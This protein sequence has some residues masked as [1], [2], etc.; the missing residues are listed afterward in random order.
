MMI[1][2]TSLIRQFTLSLCGVFLFVIIVEW[3]LININTSEQPSLSSLS[4]LS[5]ET[6]QLLSE[7]SVLQ[8]E[9][10]SILSAAPL[11]IEGRDPIESN[12]NDAGQGVDKQSSNTSLQMRLM[13]LTL[14]AADSLALIID[15]NGKYHRLFVGSEALGWKLVSVEKNSATFNRRGKTVTLT[16]EKHQI[17]KVKKAYRSRQLRMAKPPATLKKQLL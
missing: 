16:L 7:L 10:Y 3:V 11:F 4:D 13:G 2:N 1:F 5:Q 15:S 8:A 17:G 14:S 9:D 12:V 6:E